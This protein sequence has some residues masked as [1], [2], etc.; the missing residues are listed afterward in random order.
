MT[1]WIMQSDVGDSRVLSERL[2]AFLKRQGSEK[3]VARLVGCDQ[4]T[5]RGLRSGD[6]WPNR[7]HMLALW[8]AFGADVLEAVFYPERVEARLAKEKQAREQERQERIASAAR[9][10]EPPSIGLARRLGEAGRWD[11]EP[12]GLDPDNLDLFD[13]EPAGA[14]ADA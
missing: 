5:A 8:I 6:T 2:G 12:A 4:R 1:D 11:E 10:V 3:E 14:H 9:L 13:T 7:R